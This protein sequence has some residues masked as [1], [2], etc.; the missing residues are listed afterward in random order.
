[1]TGKFKMIL[2][3]LLIGAVAFCVY[4]FILIRTVYYEIGG[5]KIPSRYNI[6][7]GSVR[8]ITGYAGKTNLRTVEAGKTSKMGLT[9]EEVA[10]AK[11]RWAVFEE[12][13]NSRKEYRGWQKDSDI[14]K[15]ANEA[16]KKQLE[17]Y[18]R[19][20]KLNVPENTK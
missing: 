1:M 6:I 18:R 4:K 15:R 11:L 2:T 5:I 19:S 9:D 14:F 8:P 10:M 12:W 13:A 7:T 16:F 17:S 20:M 3:L